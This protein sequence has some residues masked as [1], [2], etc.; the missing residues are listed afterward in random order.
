MSRHIKRLLLID[1]DESI[2]K[3]LTL[4]LERSGYTVLHA[5]N[6]EEG[7]KLLSSRDVDAVILDLMMPVMDGLRFLD[8]A[9]NQRGME[10]PILVLTGTVNSSTGTRDEVIAA[11]ATDV[12]YKPINAQ[13]LLRRVKELEH[14]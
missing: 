3:L 9:R 5:E 4:H 1:D 12:A 8:I 10:L 13:E 2:V 7:L 6:G 11:G 14:R